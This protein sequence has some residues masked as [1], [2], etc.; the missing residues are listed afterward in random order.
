MRSTRRLKAT[1]REALTQWAEAIAQDPNN[2]EAHNNRGMFYFR[3]ENYAAA[4]ED[5]S[6][7]MELDPSYGEARDFLLRSYLKRDSFTLTCATMVKPSNTLI[8]Q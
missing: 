4:I 8:K 2:V 5:F 1:R 6:R 3:E 7:V